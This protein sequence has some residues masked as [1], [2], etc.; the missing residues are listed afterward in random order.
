MTED[1]LL[2]GRVRLAQPRHGFRA[3]VDPVLLAAFVPAR[4][5]DAVLELGCGSGAAFLCL[6][7][8]VPGITVTALERDASLAELA[9]R[10]AAANG[11]AATVLT[12]DLRAAALP[13]VAHG[14]ANPPFWSGGTPS[15]DAARRQA[16]HE[17]AVLADWVSALGRAVRRRGTASLIL[18]ASRFAEAACHLRGAGFGAVVL[19]PLWPR[20]GVAAKRVLLRAVKGGRGPD[21]VLPGLALH[22]GASWSV[23]ADAVLR[24]GAALPV[25]PEFAR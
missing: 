20:A 4:A 10:N 21:V 17:Q 1:T 11:V 6:A 14:F 12:G 22:E 15:P 5:G 13:E 25:G 3:A 2:S 18:P 7:T 23:A 8:R 9:T 16:S 19:C 24:D